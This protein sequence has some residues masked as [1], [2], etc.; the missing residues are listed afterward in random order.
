MCLYVYIY[1]YREREIN[2]QTNKSTHKQATSRYIVRHIHVYIDTYIPLHL[3]LR[4]PLK[5]GTYGTQLRK[6]PW[7]DIGTPG[8]LL[9]L[10]GLGLQLCGL[11]GG[12]RLQERLFGSL[13]LQI[14][15]SPEPCEDMVYSM[16]YNIV[17]RSRVVAKDPYMV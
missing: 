12:Q 13:G 8:S 2:K 9:L 10:L 11:G 6:A 3:Y 4:T 17:Y 5:F 16:V 14:C 15:C 7:S 1:M